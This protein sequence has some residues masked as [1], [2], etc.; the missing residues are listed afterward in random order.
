MSLYKEDSHQRLTTTTPSPPFRH[1][2]I[3]LGPCPRVPKTLPATAGP[4]AMYVPSL[5]PMDACLGFFPTGWVSHPRSVTMPS[6]SVLPPC[7]SDTVWSVLGYGGA[8]TPA[9]A[10]PAASASNS[11]RALLGCHIQ[12]GHQYRCSSSWRSCSALSILQVRISSSG[13]LCPLATPILTAS[14]QSSPMLTAANGQTSPNPIPSLD[15]SDDSRT[16]FTPVPLTSLHSS[17]TVVR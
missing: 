12:Q 10:G 5:P 2:A 9:T 6:S 16:S 17:P 14:P 8:A 3:I 15:G 1:D 13:N 4:A 7:P 11:N